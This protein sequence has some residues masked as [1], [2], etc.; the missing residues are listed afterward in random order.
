MKGISSNRTLFKLVA[1]AAIL[2]IS[3]LSTVNASVIVSAQTAIDLCACTGPVDGDFSIIEGGTTTTST[4]SGANVTSGSAIL[5]GSS[6]NNNGDGIGFSGSAALNDDYFSVGFD[7]FMDIENT[8]AT[9]TYD[10]IL[11][12]VFSNSVA[13][14]GTDAYAYTD[15]F[16]DLNGVE[17]FFTYLYSDT[18]NGNTI[19]D[20]DT[21]N[22]G[23]AL[24]ESGTLLFNDTLNPLET[25]QFV[26]SLTVDGRDLWSD[27]SVSFDF[28]QF[29]SVE[30]IQAQ[31]V[32]Q[33][34]SAPASLFLFL[35]AI[36]GLVARNRKI[37][38]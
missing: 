32:A 9:T 31:G 6:L 12:L 29:L 14:S 20:T 25:L 11:K 17:E 10:V 19:G 1:L 16:M 36:T 28:S 26:L 35:M 22:D 3:T 37:K 30:S 18:V 23:G 8:S 15:F 34:V 4:Y 13:A 24:S 38:N 33:D 2:S 21:G 27:G 5:S 7:S